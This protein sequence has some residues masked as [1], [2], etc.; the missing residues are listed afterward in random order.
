[1]AAERYPLRPMNQEDQSSVVHRLRAGDTSAFDAVYAAE[2]A[3]LYGFLLRLSRDPHA[4][5]DLFQNVWLKLAKNASSLRPDSNIRAW[6]LTVARRE[7]VS[8]RRAQALDVSRLLVLNRELAEA[9][10]DTSLDSQLLALKAA[11]S[12]LGDPDREVLLLSSVEGIDSD[13]VAA[14]LGISNA[15]LRQR[16]AR[17]RRRLTAALSRER[18]LEQALTPVKGAR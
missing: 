8:F 5:A 4:S 10:A 15:A 12:R 6:L 7:Y 11:I 13:Q 9:P 2:K 18:E 14:S 17:A 3:G 1:M 16:L